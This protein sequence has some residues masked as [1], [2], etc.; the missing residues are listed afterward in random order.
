MKSIQTIMAGFSILKAFFPLEKN[1]KAS[2]FGPQKIFFQGPFS[3]HSTYVILL[4]ER[5]EK[6][7]AQSLSFSLSLTAI[8]IHLGN[9]PISSKARAG[10]RTQ[11]KG[12]IDER[13]L[14]KRRANPDSWERGHCFYSKEQV[15]FFLPFHACLLA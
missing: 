12:E 14:K 11:I 9:G 8:T 6:T 15:F 5:R 2:P 4:G 13:S 10:R 7:D 3:L 1:K